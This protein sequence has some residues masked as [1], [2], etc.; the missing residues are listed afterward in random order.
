MEPDFVKNVVIEALN[1]EAR[2]EVTEDTLD[3]TIEELWLDS[4]DEVKVIMELE[5]RLCINI[6]NDNLISKAA[7]QTISEFIA[8]V[9]KL[10]ADSKPK[11]L[12]EQAT[13]TS[14]IQAGL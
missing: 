4:L 5:E 3:L 6:E 12:F 9:E 10:V 7:K 13:E 2:I 11:S 8:T 1:Q 14:K